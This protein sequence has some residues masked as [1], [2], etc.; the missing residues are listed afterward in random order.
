MFDDI[1][2]EVTK[3]QKQQ[4]LIISDIRIANKTVN[5]TFVLIVLAGS[6]RFNVLS[7]F[8][9]L[10]ESAPRPVRHYQYLSWND[11]DMSQRSIGILDLIAQA[12]QSSRKKPMTVMC[13]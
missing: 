1:S 5:F 7:T 4:S 10:K 3:R 2:V 12:E 9:I 6:R 13:R 8:I 11:E